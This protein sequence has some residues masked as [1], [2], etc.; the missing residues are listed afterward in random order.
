M[1]LAHAPQ[2]ARS[3]RRTQAGCAAFLLAAGITAPLVSGCARV[4]V[5]GSAAEARARLLARGAP[6]GIS[7]RGVGSVTLRRPGERRAGARAR[8]AAE[9]ESVAVAGYLGPARV[10]DASLRGDSIYVALRHY[11][12]GVLGPLR[13]DEGISGPLLR[14]VATPWDWSAPW[15]RAALMRASVERAGEGWIFRGGL[16]LDDSLAAPGGDPAQGRPPERYRFTVEL[17]SKGAPSRC[18]LRRE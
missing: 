17:T 13:P 4:P 12:L 14:F 11:G 18:T 8:W 15:I 2:R 5:A 16:S 7:M 10:L 1:G 3:R 6:G 9:G